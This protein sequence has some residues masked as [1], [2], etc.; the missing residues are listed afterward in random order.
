MQIYA[1]STGSFTRGARSWRFS[2]GHYARPLVGGSLIKGVFAKRF[3]NLPVWLLFLALFNISNGFRLLGLILIFRAG[4]NSIEDPN[5]IMEKES[6][7]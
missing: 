5:V 3:S 4:N 7:S 6:R 1:L 2:L